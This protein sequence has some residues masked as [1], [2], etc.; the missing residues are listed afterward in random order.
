[1]TKCEG[2]CWPAIIYVVLAVISLVLSITMDDP[3]M[4]TVENTQQMRVMH[5]IFHVFMMIFWTAIIYWLC[6]SCHPTWAWVVLFLPFFIGLVLL[7]VGTAVIT[8]VYAGR[9]VEQAV[10]RV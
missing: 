1:M 9:A 6:A 8:G 2:W 10:K 3:F 5:T 7:A 4:G